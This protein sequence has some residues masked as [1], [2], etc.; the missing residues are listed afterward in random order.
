MKRVLLLCGLLALPVWLSAQEALHRPIRGKILSSKDSIPLIGAVIEIKGTDTRTVSDNKGEFL[1]AADIQNPTLIITYLGYTS[2]V[3]ELEEIFEEIV[4]FPLEEEEMSLLAVE[5]VSTGYQKLPKERATGSFV[6]VDQ[7]LLNR[8]VST[9][10]LDRLEDVTPGL[11]FNRGAGSSGDPISIRGRNT[12]FAETNPL[13]I[14]DNF[15]YDGPLE[16]INPNDVESITVLRDA[17]AA[18][19]WG[20]R[21]GNG[22]IVI[23][24]KSGSFN[25]PLQVSLNANV[26]VIE[27]RDLFYNPLMDMGEFVSVEQLLFERGL[28]SGRINQVSRPPLSPGVE[29]MIAYSEGAIGEEERDRFLDQYRSQDAR[30]D[31]MDHFYRKT[32]NR[33][34]SVN[35]NGGTASNRYSFSVGYDTNLN[36]IVGN[37]DSRVTISGQHTWKFLKDKLEI[38]AGLYLVNGERTTATSV[39]TLYPYERVVDVQGNPLPVIRDYSQRYIN[40]TLG[41]GF[42]DWEYR[43]VEEIGLQDQRIAQND[44]RVNT[45]IDYNFTKNL[46]LNVLYQYW[47]NHNENRN[48]QPLESYETRNQINRFM[49]VGPDGSLTPAIPIGGILSLANTS[50]RSH[51]IRSQFNYQ[52]DW[53]NDHQFNALAG[54]EL[55]DLQL[56]SNNIRYFGYDDQFGLSQP[57][58]FLTRYRV[59]PNN[60]LSSIPNGVNHGGIVDRFYSSFA[61][62]GY[63]YK[64]RYLLSGSIRRDASNIFGVETN[65]RGVPLWS[66]GIGWIISQEP[67]Y[68]SGFIPYLKLRTTYGYNGNVDKTLSAY[69]TASYFISGM[70]HL[71]PGIRIAQIVNPPNPELRWER[72]GIWNLGIDFELIN[73]I[74]SGSIELYKKQGTDLIGDSP[75]HP[76]SGVT[77]FRGNFA[78]TETKGIDVNFHSVL[79][80]RDVKWTV[81]LLYSKVRERVTDYEVESPTINYVTSTFTSPLEGNPLFSIYSYGWA[82]LDPDTGDPLGFVNGEA[83]SNYR[84]IMN[85]TSP[86]DLVFHGSLRPTSFGALRNSF[87][88]RGVNLSVNISYRLGYYYRRESVNYFDLLNGRITHSDYHLRWQQPGD[89]LFTQVPSMPSASDTD[90]NT[91]YSFSET[92]VEKGDHIR[93]QDIRIGYGLNRGKFRRLPFQSAEIYTYVN[94]LGIL[95]KASDDPL[96]PDFRTMRPLTSVAIGARIDF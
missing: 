75:V 22:V 41:M 91:F 21:A 27:Q 68:Q 74:L 39:P 58:D 67:F 63:T 15:P 83:S 46:K 64:N 79:V 18:S 12:I 6:Q 23:T 26:N 20:A 4:A 73:R 55:K 7:E 2:G 37:S 62:A 96:D 11:I 51:S 3:F 24:T 50:S 66:S 61:N 88:W 9:N 71:V 47:Q 65:Q 60:A 72:I 49:Q 25:Q 36:D 90:R 57:M 84:Q 70:F 19:I 42:L 81:D 40:S 44:Y 52:I 16:N 56:E 87:Q 14:I 8:R 86:S 53:G 13:I 34:Y 54:L 92:L 59:Q 80:E 77:L 82:G 69:T 38:S 35:L 5:V 1:L 28:Y 93:L 29:A 32:V 10:I 45:S 78:S 30:R 31:L 43:P 48:H 76:S 89:E 94:N 95:W 17:A 33:Q 85:E